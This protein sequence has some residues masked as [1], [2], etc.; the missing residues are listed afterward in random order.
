MTLGNREISLVPLKVCQQNW[1]IKIHLIRIKLPIAEWKEPV[2]K[3]L[4]VAS[5][6]G[7]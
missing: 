6:C 7:A 2:C 4:R 3:G 1:S 5:R